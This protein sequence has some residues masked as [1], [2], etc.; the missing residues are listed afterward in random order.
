MAKLVCREYGFECDYII[1]GPED[2]V[3]EG[4]KIHMEEKHGIEY[5]YEAIQQFVMRKHDL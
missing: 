1:E 3:I 5:S 4:F 2:K